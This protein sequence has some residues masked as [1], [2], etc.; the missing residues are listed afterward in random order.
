MV[1][2]KKSV[3]YILARETVTGSDGRGTALRCLHMG[4]YL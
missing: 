4:G 1:V 2:S 3:T